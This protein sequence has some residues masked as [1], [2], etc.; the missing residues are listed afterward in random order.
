MR[1]ATTLSTHSRRIEDFMARN[2]PWEEIGSTS[3][4][5]YTYSRRKIIMNRI[6]P[7][8]RLE[9]LFISKMHSFHELERIK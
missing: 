3:E 7:F 9:W 8:Q 4:R 1:K 6:C 2:V 5:H